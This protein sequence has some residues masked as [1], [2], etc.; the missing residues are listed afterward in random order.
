[1]KKDLPFQA[2]Y[3]DHK[4]HYQKQYTYHWQRDSND[5]FERITPINNPK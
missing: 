4:K 1:M 5:Y 2:A 3:T